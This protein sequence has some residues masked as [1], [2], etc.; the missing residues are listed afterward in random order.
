MHQLQ[1]IPPQNLAH[2]P[3]ESVW[4]ANFTSP[5][6]KKTYRNAVGQ[7]FAFV[8]VSHSLELKNVSTAHLIA[9]RETLQQ[10]GASPRT[11][12][13][14]LSAV[15]SL[16]KYLCQAQYIP[17]NPAENVKRLRVNQSTV[18]TPVLTAEQARK[19]LDSVEGESLKAWRDRA[20]LHSL[21]YTGCRITEVTTLRVKDFLEDNGYFVLDFTVKGG[22]KNRVAIHQEL[23]IALRFYL[24]KS[25]H[26]HE[27]E[28]PLFLPVKPQGV[29]KRITSRQL[30]KLFHQY[31]K[32]AGLPD[33]ITP[34]STRATFITNALEQKCPIEAVQKS[35]A[36]ANI[37]TTQAYDKREMHYRESASFKVHY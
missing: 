26:A 14:K 19:L 17:V 1:E 23:Q 16:F 21:L 35:V 24:A 29:R 8:G 30:N 4:L 7:F 15:S 31:R 32:K 34:H 18:E 33:T 25:D 2:I 5:Q 37:S 28:S 12:N 11:I 20:L 3:P 13:N 9:W 6:T 36:H 22:K 27:T 10:G